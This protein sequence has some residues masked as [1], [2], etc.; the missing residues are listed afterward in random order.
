M[1]YFS[2]CS[3]AGCDP[4]LT[5]AI[6]WKEQKV[7]SGVYLTCQAVILAYSL[8]FCFGKFVS[9]FTFVMHDFRSSKIRKHKQPF[10]SNYIL[11]A[12]NDTLQTGLGVENGWLTYWFRR[13]HVFGTQESICSRLM[14]ELHADQS[15]HVVGGIRSETS[16]MY[17]LGQQLALLICVNSSCQQETKAALVESNPWRRRGLLLLSLVF[18][19]QEKQWFVKGHPNKRIK[20]LQVSDLLSNAT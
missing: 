15:D 3:A 16:I 5:R 18:A 1:C 20:L 14:G 8:P 12:S 17:W 6:K 7:H 4:N 9:K 13:A 2:P 11:L 19:T 10:C